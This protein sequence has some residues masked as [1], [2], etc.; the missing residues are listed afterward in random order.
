MKKLHVI[1]IGGNI[2][3]DSKLLDQ[4]LIDFSNIQDPKILVHGG[5]KTATAMAER[6]GIVQHFSEGRRITDPS[7]LEVAVMVY[8]G[9][10]NKQL[11]ARLHSFNQNAAGFCGADLNLIQSVK[12][13]VVT[14]D[15]GWVGDVVENGVNTPMFKML[16]ENGIVPVLCAIT[17]DH[18]GNLLNTNADTLASKV[19]VALSSLYKITLTYC[20]EKKG[21]LLNLNDNESYYKQLTPKEYLKLKKEGTIHN[22]MIPKLDNAFEALTKGIKAVNICHGRHINSIQQNNLTGT[23]LLH[24]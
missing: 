14:A 16:L 21:V 3:D 19:A 1:K 22:G 7:T 24:D 4:F 11:V 2:I 9:L 5:G 12:R 6:L 20:F 23:Q 18:E 13:P 17:H 8:A 10:I 15:F